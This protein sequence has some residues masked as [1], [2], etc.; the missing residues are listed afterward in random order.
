MGLLVSAS[1]RE[2]ADD[3]GSSELILVVEDQDDVCKVI[4][5]TLELQGYEVLSTRDPN[6]A[7]AMLRSLHRPLDLLVTDV[8]MPGMSGTALAQEAQVLQA[9]L[10]VLFVSGHPE[11][12]LFQHGV[13]V[14]AENFLAKPFS[15]ASL[16]RKV[17]K[18]L[19]R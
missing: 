17:R 12:T 6:E 10:K 9:N 4:R 8:V 18:L 16:G 7:I 13:D 3:D 11:A 2:T 19:R 5:L 1:D 14:D 15:S